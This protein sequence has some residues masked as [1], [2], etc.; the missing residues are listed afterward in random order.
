MKWKWEKKLKKYKVTKVDKAFLTYVWKNLQKLNEK[1]LI[2][3]LVS[4]L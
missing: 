4:L 2:L 1:R 3:L